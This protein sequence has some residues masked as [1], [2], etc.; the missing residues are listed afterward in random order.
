MSNLILVIGESGTGKSTSIETL[1]P[2]ETFI[3]QVVQKP[4]PFRGFKKNYPIFS[5]ENPKGNRVIAKDH[6][7]ILK[8]LQSIEINKSIKTVVV[9]DF[10]YVLRAW[11]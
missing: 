4:L 7:W 6:T 3:I 11:I 5:K 1:D 10:Q 9:D 2:K 8:A